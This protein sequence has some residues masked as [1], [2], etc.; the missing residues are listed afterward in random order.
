[1][2]KIYIVLIAVM[3]LMASACTQNGGHLGKL[4]GRWHLERIEADNM[5]APEQDGELYWAFQNDMI[6]MQLDLGEHEFQES[7]GLFRMDDNSLYLSFPEKGNPP[8][9][10][11]GLAREDVLQILK[12][13]GNEFILQYNPTPD[14]SLTYYFRKW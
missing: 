7:Y 10:E 13:T 5:E 1:M 2:K 14:S 8:L 11:T 3:A 4:F 9:P 6:Q 12:L